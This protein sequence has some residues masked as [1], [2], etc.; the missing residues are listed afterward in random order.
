MTL[1]LTLKGCLG[2]ALLLLMN[3]NLPG[4]PINPDQVADTPHNL[5]VS[6]PGTVRA[7]EE[8][9]I[10][11]FCHTPHGADPEAPLWNR[12]ETTTTFEIYP[13][14][15]SM[16]SVPLQ[17]NGSS[18]ICLSC[19]DGTSALGTVRSLP[20]TIPLYGVSPQG[21]LPEGSSNL[22][23]S[24]ADDHPVSFVP[25][26]TDPEIILPDPASPVHLDING[27]V[28][29]RSCHD[30][31]DN[32]YGHF[33]VTDNIESAI[34]VTCHN[35]VDWDI[36]VHGH[37]SD[38]QFQQL[39][40]QGCSSCHEPHSAPESPRLL[41]LSEENLCFACHDGVQ[42]APWEVSG[43]TDLVLEFQKDSVHPIEVNPGVH[44]PGEGPINSFPPPSQF[45]PEQDPTA[46]RHV[47]C[48]DCH[49]PHSA[50]D[51]DPPGEINGA[52]AN[53]WGI[54][55]S[56]Q[57]VDEATSEFQICFK[58]HG[59]SQNLP[60]GESNKRLE[61]LT[62]NASYHPVIAPGTNPSVPSLLSPWTEQS[63]MNCSDCH[64]NDDSQGP[65]GPHGS[66]YS[67]ILKG[68]YYTGWGQ[69][70]DPFLYELCYSCH[71]R[72]VIFSGMMSGSFRYHKKHVQQE[73]K[74]SCYRCHTSHGNSEN[75]HLIRFDDD[76]PEI[77]P[78][79]SGRLEYIDNGNGH[80]SCYVRCH[81][82]N[83]NP[84]NY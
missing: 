36:S 4:Q 16:Q 58:C 67:P 18:L 40:Q 56:G 26:L 49:N 63:V 52:L 6:G 9:R 15:G 73:E 66:V 79:S 39:V 17:P 31:H 35:K 61:F 60:P 27:Q 32:T 20:Y 7:V 38:P 34:C 75:T 30:P 11:I 59:D 46:L 81:G 25:S 23:I 78:S 72:N 21:T 64:G 51:V 43:A 54:A 19:H 77:D 53:L 48:A 22:G 57:K 42:N 45:L 47:E 29:C 10:C 24:L 28:Q 33:L 74:D 14:G 37:P 5:S 69:S 55:E 82:E 62:S 13:S 44:D 80:G 50:N 3:V 65:A 84:K 71:D 83:H 1:R 2:L 12:Y 8:S 76:M 41:I 68:N 70:E